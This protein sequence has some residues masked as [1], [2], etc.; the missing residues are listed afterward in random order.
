MTRIQS[1]NGN[2]VVT[3]V[4]NARRRRSVSVV[5][6]VLAIAMGWPRYAQAEVFVYTDRHGRAHR[7]YVSYER[8]PELVTDDSATTPGTGEEPSPASSAESEASASPSSGLARSAHG[9][10]KPGSS[11]EAYLGTVREAADHYRLPVQLVIAVI[12]VESAFNPKAVSTAGAMGLMQLMPDTARAMWVEDPFDPRQNIYGGTRFLRSLVNRFD[13]DVALALAAY[14]A[15][16]EAVERWRSIPPYPKTT[17]YVSKVLALYHWQ[18][19]IR[20]R[21]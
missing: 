21:R 4:A 9:R 12:L 20:A 14:H 19:G 16:P 5:A 2:T 10:S 15:G 6:S 7:V 1:A 8:E 3:P 17:D 13:G 11:A 18:L